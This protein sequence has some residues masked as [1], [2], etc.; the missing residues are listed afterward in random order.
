MHATGL[1]LWA[2]G[3]RGC[4]WTKRWHTTFQLYSAHVSSTQRCQQTGGQPSLVA[5]RHQLQIW[6]GSFCQRSCNKASSAA[7]FHCYTS[8]VPVPVPFTIYVYVCLLNCLSGKAIYSLFWGHKH[9]YQ[10]IGARRSEVM[11]FVR[12]TGFLPCNTFQVDAT[13]VGVDNINV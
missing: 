13:L 10:V 11:P 1:H 5:L 3:H 7:G 9:L 12:R 8:A 2:H 6:S 4:L